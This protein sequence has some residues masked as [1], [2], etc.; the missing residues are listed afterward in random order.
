LSSSETNS[1]MKSETGPTAAS[2]EV[3][4][5]AADAV[6]AQTRN[7]ESAKPS[8]LPLLLA[9]LALLLAAGAAGLVGW[10]FYGSSMGSEQREAQLESQLAQ[11]K[12]MV[13][14]SSRKLEQEN[15]LVQR[16][17]QQEMARLSQGQSSELE[18]L[19]EVVQQQRR[20]LLELGTTDRSDWML[21][22]VEYLLRLAN[23][24]LVMAADVKSAL[25]LLGSADG[26]VR[27]LDDASLLGLRSAIAS[28]L[29][30]LRAVPAV[31]VEGTWLRL[32]A[33]VGEVD[34][35]LLFEIPELQPQAQAV[36]EDSTWMDRLQHGLYAAL[37]RFR[38]YIVIN[39][40]E[41][42]YQALL[43]PQWEGLVRQNLRMLLEQSRSALLNGNQRLYQQSLGD[44]RRWLGEFFSFNEASVA[45]L[46]AELESLGTLDINPQLPDLT[47]SLA[48]VSLVIDE[49]HNTGS[50]GE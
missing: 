50:G 20:R 25:A 10:Q 1:D 9:L 18:A 19:K 30:A 44:T 33:L 13:E 37:A 7:G 47:A 32:Q 36:P 26:I 46:D 3:P 40:R 31:D 39:R 42:P 2:T 23:Q 45:A 48:A 35:L 24:R 4:V 22:E 14:A 28:D 29:A 34:K 15:E 8:R 49:K 16:G 11:L 12:S 21:A 38:S 43:D 41:E 17:L 27:D 6:P 5:P